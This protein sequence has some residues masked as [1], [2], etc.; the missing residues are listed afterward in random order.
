MIKC[1][2]TVC[3]TISRTAQMRTGKE[4]KPFMSLGINVVIPAKSG[5]NKTVEISVAKDGGSQEE[6]ANYPVGNRVEVVGT[7]TFH[8]KGE[9]FYLNLSATGINTFSAGSEDSIKGDIEFR[10][11]KIEEKK[12]KKGN[13]FCVFSAFS[14]EKNGE[15]YDYTWIRFLQFGESRKDWMQPKA[16]IN[17]KGELQMS[18]YNDRLDIA[19]RVSEVGINAKGELQMSVYNDRL[20]IACRVSEVSKW[21][22]TANNP[23]T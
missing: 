23:N 5:I 18:V 9:A 17:A 8:K 13:P 21:D 2:V 6:L 4:G 22:K 15:N 12:D 14:S 11:T 1:N 3:G 10:G 16:G 7:L 19:C 20:D